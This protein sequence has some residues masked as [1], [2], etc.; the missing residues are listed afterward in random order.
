MRNNSR[1]PLNET[2]S[3]KPF[4]AP[5][6]RPSTLRKSTH[7]VALEP[8]RPGLT[9]ALRPGGGMR[10][11]K[12][13][14]HVGPVGRTGSPIYSLRCGLLRTGPP[15]DDAASRC[16]PLAATSLP[17]LEGGVSASPCLLDNFMYQCAVHHVR[18]AVVQLLSSPFWTIVAEGRSD[19]SG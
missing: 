17:R 2:G 1:L 19:L 7:S 13:H 3:V 12:H 5:E 10:G 4:Q 15:R 6:P 14:E 8:P 16:K 9:R 18:L 11:E